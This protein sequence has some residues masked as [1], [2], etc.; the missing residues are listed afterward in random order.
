MDGA[1]DVA[2]RG[3]GAE[4]RRRVRDVVFDEVVA[5]ADEGGG[6]VARKEEGGGVG[7]VAEGDVA[8]GVED[9][10]VVE[11]VGGRD[12]GRQA[13]P[14]GGIVATYMRSELSCFSAESHRGYRGAIACRRR[15]NWSEAHWRVLRWTA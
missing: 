5:G 4:D 13:L 9:G 1:L 10:V 11:D 8:V 7:G 2:V 14:Q 15:G 3:L 12:Q 6:E